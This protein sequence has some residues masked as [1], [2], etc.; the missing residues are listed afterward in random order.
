MYT[1][2]LTFRCLTPDVTWNQ[3]VRPLVVRTQLLDSTRILP[4]NDV[5]QLC[6]SMWS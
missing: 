2:L 1:A 4:I 6:G 3:S 5:S